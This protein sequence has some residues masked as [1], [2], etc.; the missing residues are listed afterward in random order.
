[1]RNLLEHLRVDARGERFSA[2][3]SQDVV[4]GEHAHSVSGLN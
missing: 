3:A 4:D 1:M 2:D